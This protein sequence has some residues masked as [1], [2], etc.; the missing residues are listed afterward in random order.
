M[1]MATMGRYC[2]AYPVEQLRAFPGWQERLDNL[3]PAEHDEDGTTEARTSLGNEDYLF[4]HETLVVTDG[5]F[6]DEHIVFD[7]VTPEWTEFCTRELAF[8]VPDYARGDDL[9]AT[10]EPETASTP[11]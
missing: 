6:L 7:Q 4:L 8:E 11:S 5:I 10:P 1:T 2:K 9:P 3:A